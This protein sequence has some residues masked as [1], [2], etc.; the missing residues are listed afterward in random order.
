[1]PQ[2]TPKIDVAVERPPRIRDQAPTGIYGPD[3][4][5][6]RDGRVLEC[7]TCRRVVWDS[8][9][10]LEPGE[11]IRHRCKCGQVVVRWGEGG[12][13]KEQTE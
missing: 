6:L 3:G 1:M 4:G 7:P 5:I 2:A 9:V 8:N 12:E 13:A 10:S 11:Y